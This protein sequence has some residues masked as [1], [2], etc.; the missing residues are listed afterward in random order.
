MNSPRPTRISLEEVVSRLY[1]ALDVREWRDGAL[2]GEITVRSQ[3]V[4]EFLSKYFDPGQFD[5]HPFYLE[6]CPDEGDPKA[7]RVGARFC[8]RFDAVRGSIGLVLPDADA[9]L[10]RA[11]VLR[12]RLLT[13]WYLVREDVA[14]WEVPSG[15]LAKLP[16]VRALVAH[17][18]QA[19]AVF[20]TLLEPLVFLHQQRFDVPLRC[21]AAALRALDV[22]RLAAL[23]AELA[24]EDGHAP[25]RAEILLAAVVEM[26][27]TE[28]EAGRFAA[29]LR[30]LPE[31]HERFVTGYRLFASAFSFDRIRDQVET[32]CVEQTTRI[33]RS[34]S[35]IQGQL[36]GVPVSTIVVATQLK[37]V[38]ADPLHLWINAAVLLGAL[39]FCVLL[40]ISVLNQLHTLRALAED[41]DYHE[42][43]LRAKDAGLVSQL[44]PRFDQLRRRIRLHRLAL[45]VVVGCALVGLLV[46]FWVA[47]QFSR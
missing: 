36:L 6:E 1:R 28:P 30:R 25:Q 16:G 34:L 32:Y 39:V 27:Q 47:W 33:H 18:E 19:A 21:D 20:D 24:R 26:L 8:F 29:L 35:D 38:S 10:A 7:V 4:A 42:R 3:P 40:S 15:D 41:V 45:Q 44:G 43:S 2:C 5:D 31:L 9:V 14:S 22:E 46:A 13:P 37:P 17:L 11:D 12:G 23:L